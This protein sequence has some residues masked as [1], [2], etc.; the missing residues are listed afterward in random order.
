MKLAIMQPYFFPYIGYWQLINC[1]DK[2]ILYDN[3]KYTKKGWIN[4]NRLLQNG[5]AVDFTLPLKKDSD[6]LHI[7]ERNI[8][9]DFNHLKLL[10]KINVLYKKSPYFEE[11]FSLCGQLIGYKESNLFNYLYNSI[12]KICSFL[13]ISTEIIISSD[14]HIDHTLKSQDKVIAI[15]KKNNADKYINAI[16]GQILYSKEIFLNENIALKFIKSKYIDY[17]QFNHDFVP[18]L[19]ILD[20]MMFNSK[21]E[22]SK[23]LEQYELVE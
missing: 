20:V 5:V 7:K 1:A 14:I 17:K 6:F 15:C 12:S 22:I 18:W 3:I 16:G 4:R 23:M 9:S 13:G 8:A 11:V 2:F 21:E 19:S 10:N